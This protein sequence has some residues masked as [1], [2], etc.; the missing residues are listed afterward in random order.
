MKQQVSDDIAWINQ[1]STEL[2]YNLYKVYILKLDVI[3]TL[4]DAPCKVFVG[5]LTGL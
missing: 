2:K 3:R 4:Y 1:V 5:G